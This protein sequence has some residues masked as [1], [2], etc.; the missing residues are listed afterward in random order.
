M[1][2]SRKHDT[3]ADGPKRTEMNRVRRYQGIKIVRAPAPAEWM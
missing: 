1:T 3:A 2:E